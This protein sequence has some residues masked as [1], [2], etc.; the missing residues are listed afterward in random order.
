MNTSWYKIPG[1]HHVNVLFRSAHCD[2]AHGL[3]W[4]PAALPYRRLRRYA[5]RCTGFRV[6]RRFL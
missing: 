5:T 1:Y 2:T 6:S 3:R 4:V